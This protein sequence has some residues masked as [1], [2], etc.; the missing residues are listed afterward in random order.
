MRRCSLGLLLCGLLGCGTGGAPAAGDAGLDVERPADGSADTPIAV[1][2]PSNVDAA[3]DSADP[4]PEVSAP[5]CD[6]KALVFEKSCVPG[7]HRK[8]A[9]PAFGSLDLESEGLEDRLWD[10]PTQG[11]ARWR[12]VDPR[13][14]ARSA[15]LQKLRSSPPFG[16]RMPLGP[17]LDEADIACVEGW[18]EE[19]IRARR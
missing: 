2:A 16:A 8:S 19:L 3:E 5:P 6:A 15:L 12:L 14:A 9:G 10:A 1:D 11:D 13:G 17:P 18:I 7:C 4:P